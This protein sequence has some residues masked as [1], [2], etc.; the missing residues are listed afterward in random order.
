V[1]QP[2]REQVEVQDV[3]GPELLEVGLAVVEEDPGVLDVGRPVLGEEDGKAPDRD[4]EQ[5]GGQEGQAPA[6]GPAL[7]RDGAYSS[8]MNG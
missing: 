4:E 8:A 5:R 3:E 2:V 7:G 1:G 6:G